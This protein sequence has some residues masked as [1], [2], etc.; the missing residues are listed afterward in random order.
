MRAGTGRGRRVGRKGE[1]GERGVGEAVRWTGARARLGNR[2]LRVA[3][4]RGGEMAGKAAAVKQRKKPDFSGVAGRLIAKAPDGMSFGSRLRVSP[5]DP[6]LDQL[7]VQ[8]RGAFAEFDHVRARAAVLNRAK[9][10]KM[11]VSFG[12]EG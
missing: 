9:A 6:L 12:V 2:A 3:S 11:R 5:Y 7:R 1:G 4:L 10:K 8:G